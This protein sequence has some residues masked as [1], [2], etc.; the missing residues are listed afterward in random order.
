MCA[1]SLLSGTLVDG[2][3]TLPVTLVYTRFIPASFRGFDRHVVENRRKNPTMTG[4]A[5]YIAGHG[6]APLLCP[7]LSFQKVNVRV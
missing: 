7:S 1:L 3:V 5:E 6:F 4:K 2:Y